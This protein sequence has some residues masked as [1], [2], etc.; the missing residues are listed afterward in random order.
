MKRP[1]GEG[2]APR[3]TAAGPTADTTAAGGPLHEESA[4]VARASAPPP[5]DPEDT[6]D[7][8]P[9]LLAALGRLL[10]SHAPEEVL[11]LVREELERRELRAYSSGWQDAAAHY[12]PALEE[13]RAARGRALRLVRGVPG[14][15][16]VIPLRRYDG[17]DN[18]GAGP[19]GGPDDGPD[20][21]PDPGP[22]DGGRAGDGAG[23]RGAAAGPAAPR[24]RTDR[25]SGTAPALVPKSRS[26]RVPTIPRLR[27]PARRPAEDTTG[28]TPEGEP[29]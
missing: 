27:P 24:G 18:P 14:Q 20:A 25:P 3:N 23:G 17:P 19:D 16:A 28:T 10:E 4:P 5:G 12:E 11:V 8:L 2:A 9:G 29:M 13:A 22:G 26:S 1:D 6:P 15:A 7:G 21:G